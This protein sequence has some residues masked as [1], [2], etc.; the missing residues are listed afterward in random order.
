MR[1]R[2]LRK[3]VG[4]LGIYT[5]AAVAGY[6]LVDSIFGVKDELLGSIGQ[7]M[8]PLTGRTDVWRELLA[9]KTDP[10]IGTGFCSIWS[11][12][13]LLSRMPDWAAGGH[14][15]HNGYLE[16][17]LDGGM[18]GIFFLAVDVAGDRR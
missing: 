1:C 18:I 13:S 10:L 8:P 3:R 14:S 9:L 5:L 11:D 17:Y 15:A 2:V 6:Y 12:K 7:E 4:A 16:I